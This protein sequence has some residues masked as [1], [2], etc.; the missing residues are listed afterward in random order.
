VNNP[1]TSILESPFISSAEI[2]ETIRSVTQS[3]I[4]SEEGFQKL[5]EEVRDPSLRRYFLEES[6]M[7]AQFRSELDA[8]LLQEGMDDINEGGTFA[9]GLHCAWGE[10]TSAMGGSDHALLVTAELGEDQEIEAYRR[11]IE[12]DLPSPIQQLLAAQV[13]HIAAS[14]DYIC[15]AALAPCR[16]FPLVSPESSLPYRSVGMAPSFA[17]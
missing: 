16:V 5:V 12:K 10:L 4:D 11:A 1:S 8:V 14:H 15:A 13:G 2:E 3:L 6:S 7:R 9:G 17:S